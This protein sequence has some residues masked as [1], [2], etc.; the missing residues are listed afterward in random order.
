M[1][2]SIQ[3]AKSIIAEVKARDASIGRDMSRW[4]MYENHI[5]TAANIA[6]IIAS[7]IKG[8]DEEQAYVNALL[9]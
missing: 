5:V 2:I 7:K 4:W 8:M 6:R 1:G 9:H 3:E